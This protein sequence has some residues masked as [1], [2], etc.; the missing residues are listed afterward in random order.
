MWNPDT[1]S[2][3]DNAPEQTYTLPEDILAM[4]LTPFGTPEPR[5]GLASKIP[6]GA[7]IECYDQGFNEQTVKVRWRGRLYFVFRQDLKTQCKS[8]D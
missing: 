2:I 1:L 8:N 7:E 6:Q 3:P 5:L 4:E